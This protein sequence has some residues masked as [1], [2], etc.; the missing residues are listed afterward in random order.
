MLNAV[1]VAIQG[2]SIALAYL[3]KARVRAG[4]RVLVCGASGA[5]ANGPSGTREGRVAIRTIGA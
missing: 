5:V 3:R 4:Q 1:G 2:A